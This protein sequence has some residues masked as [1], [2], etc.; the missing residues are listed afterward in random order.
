MPPTFLWSQ[1]KC[2]TFL[3]L[4]EWIEKVLFHESSRRSCAGKISIIGWSKKDTFDKCR[5]I[6][7][8]S[9]RST[10]FK[11]VVWKHKEDASVYITDVVNFKEPGNPLISCSWVSDCAPG[12]QAD[13]LNTIGTLFDL[14]GFRS[15]ILDISPVLLPQ[16]F[17]CHHR[18]ELVYCL[19][20]ILGQVL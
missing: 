3:S 8:S 4:S 14:R 9:N 1:A 17:G 18:R 15:H 16:L 13:T 12:F 10:Q 11:H 6:Q 19:I 5:K 2:F 7:N 20:S